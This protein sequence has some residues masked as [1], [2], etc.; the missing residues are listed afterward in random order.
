M[1]ES[2]KFKSRG[3]FGEL[4][5]HAPI[6]QV[7]A[8]LPAISKIYCKSAINDTVK[9]FDA[10]HVVGP[11]EDMELWLGGAKFYSDY[12]DAVRDVVAELKKHT[13][14]NYLRDEFLLIRGKIDSKWPQAKNLQELLSDNRSLDDVFSRVCLPVLLT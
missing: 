12:A 8:S 3:E 10:V 11:P 6:R 2:E 5:L 1:Y 4:F 14:T 13:Q 9:G 7:F